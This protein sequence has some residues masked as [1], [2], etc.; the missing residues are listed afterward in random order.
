MLYNGRLTNLS[1]I[2]ISLKSAPPLREIYKWVL[3]TWHSG[4][5]YLKVHEEDSDGRA[6]FIGS[7]VDSYQAM[8][9]PLYCP[10]VE[11]QFR[12]LD[13]VGFF[14]GR[15]V[16]WLRLVRIPRMFDEEGKP[17]LKTLLNVLVTRN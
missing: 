4:P 14:E 12:E 15:E 17:I 6:R 11:E 9:K 10:V 8:E 1:K 5:I 13:E 7:H 3:H 2:F 16:K